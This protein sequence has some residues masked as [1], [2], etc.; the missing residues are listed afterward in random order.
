MDKQLAAE[1]LQISL[2]LGLKSHVAS[3]THSVRGCV[4][5]HAYIPLI[6]RTIVFC[7][8]LIQGPI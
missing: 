7:L 5:V 3:G 2:W 4:C 8:F 6:T 1:E